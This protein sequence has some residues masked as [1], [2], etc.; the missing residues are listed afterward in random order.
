MD[1]AFRREFIR[2]N[3][4]IVAAASVIGVA[5]PFF[6]AEKEEEEVSLAEDLMRERGCSNAFS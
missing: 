2:K 3:G 6:A 4:L 5:G 1:I